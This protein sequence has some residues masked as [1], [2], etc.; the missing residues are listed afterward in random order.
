MDSLHSLLNG[1][2]CEGPARATSTLVLH[3]DHF[4]SSTPIERFSRTLKVANFVSGTVVEVSAAFDNLF[5][6]QEAVLLHAFVG[7]QVGHF[8]QRESDTFGMR[9]HFLDPVSAGLE[10][11]KS[12][13]QFLY[14][15]VVFSILGGEAQECT[16]FLWRVSASCHCSGA[17]HSKGKVGVHFE[18][19]LVFVF[20]FDY[21][22]KILSRLY[23]MKFV[24]KFINKSDRIY[25]NRHQVLFKK[26]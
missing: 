24:K 26:F 8:I 16:L 23:S 20:V 18:V 22:L 5:G 15:L 1:S 13:L 10:D 7:S 25:G 3:S 4:I 21:C 12:F 17:E 9:V 14:V 19:G 2:G 6:H 11:F